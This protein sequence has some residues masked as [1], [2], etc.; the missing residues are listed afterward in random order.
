MS[1]TAQSL[2]V[3]PRGRWAVLC[4]CAGASLAAGMARA[5]NPP[6]KA[7]PVDE[8]TDPGPAPAVRPPRA[9][10]VPDA[11][12]E[13]APRTQPAAAR[14]APGGA[15]K[16]PEDD[17]FGASGWLSRVPPNSPADAGIAD[18]SAHSG[19]LPAKVRTHHPHAIAQHKPSNFLI[20]RSPLVD[21][22]QCLH[23]VL[24][25]T[26]GRSS[27]ERNPQV[28]RALAGCVRQSRRSRK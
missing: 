16:T 13:P 8:R 23:G 27:R 24:R 12:P 10:P 15:I 4:A 21:I 28:R 9:T 26:V 19:P 6:P 17:L 5:Q 18:A 7:L 22:T 20:G 3:L 2:R 11:A 1:K 25:S 14:P